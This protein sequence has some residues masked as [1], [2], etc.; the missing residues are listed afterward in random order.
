LQLIFSAQ[1]NICD[2]RSPILLKRELSQRFRRLDV[3]QAHKN[4][5]AGSDDVL[6]ELNGVEAA[7]DW[8][9]SL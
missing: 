6:C 7:A 5:L 8:A 2:E 3:A 1:K 4:G 9:S